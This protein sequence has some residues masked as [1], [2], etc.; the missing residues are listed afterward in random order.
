M[1]ARASISAVS[2][3]TNVCQNTT[4]I[5]VPATPTATAIHLGG[6]TP[7]ASC[8]ATYRSNAVL[9]AITPTNVPSDACASRRARSVCSISPNDAT[10]STADVVSSVAPIDPA[11]TNARCGGA[12]CAISETATPQA[13]NI[14]ATIRAMVTDVGG[15]ISP[16]TAPPTLPRIVAAAKTRANR[17]LP[18]H[19]AI[20]AATAS[21]ISTTL[22]GRFN[23]KPSI[24]CRSAGASLTHDQIV[25][26][27]V[28]SPT[29]AMDGTTFPPRRS[30]AVPTVSDSA[31]VASIS[32]CS[33]M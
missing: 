7:T 26:T 4:I 1:R 31:V 23:A 32:P 6:A 14:A 17:R 3:A 12:S 25:G 8:A 13:K 33:A 5:T 2:R 16:T 21:H 29:S 15:T 18:L 10:T 9:R 19:V 30:V 28:A 22:T 24:G 11:I 27:V 20:S